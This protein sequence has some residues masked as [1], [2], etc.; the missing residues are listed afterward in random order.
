[1]ELLQVDERTNYPLT[2]SVDDLGDGFRLT[3]H[4]DESVEAARICGYMERAL[5]GI[6]TALES[7]PQTAVHMIDV[8]PEQERH[9]VL[10][11]WNA[12]AAENGTEKCIHELFEEQVVRRPGAVALV[13]EGKELTYGELNCRANQLAHY[14]RDM[15]VG[16]EVRVGI[17]MERSLE[18]VI[19]LLGVWKA[20]GVYVPVDPGYPAERVSYMLEDAQVPVLLT[21]KHLVDRLPVSWTQVVSVDSRWEEIAK[22]SEENPEIELDPQNT[23]YVIYT[24]GSTGQ[25]K[26]VV[27]EHRGLC[28][29][30][31]AQIGGFG[32]EVE[33]RILQFASFSFDASVWEFMMALCRGAVLHMPGPGA[34]LMEET[35]VG[36]VAEHGIT[37]VTLPPAVLAT[38]GEEKSL[39]SVRTLIV[40][41]DTLT[42]ELAEKWIQDRE[43]INAYGPTEATV[44]ATMHRWEKG[45]GKPPIGRPIANTRVYILDRY[46]EPA[47][48][49]VTGEI[50]IGGAC[51]ARGYLNRPGLTAE[52]FVADPF[53]PEPGARMYKTGDLG[54]WLADGNIDFLGR[55]DLQVKIRGFRIE[56]GE[57]EARLR[58]HAGVR[59]AVVVARQ[60]DEPGDKRLVAYYTAS[61]ASEDEPRQAVSVE[62]LRAHLLTKLPEYMVPS[63]WVQLEVLPLTPNDKLDRKALPAPAAQSSAGRGYEAPQGEVETQIAGI[64]AEILRLEQVGR[65]DNFFELG[66]HS[67][68][69]ARLVSRLREAFDVD[70]P[71][72]EIFARPVLSSLAEYVLDK[73]LELYDPDCLSEALRYMD[74]APAGNEEGRGK[75][76]SLRHAVDKSRL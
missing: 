50:F 37:H 21:Q 2:L 34:V 72:N 42:E 4:V 58:E 22:H 45:T 20:G 5:D 9:Q 62:E 3:V 31:T 36:M 48:V 12:T 70:V 33:S 59:E 14:L 66:G 8:L 69:A 29:M 46:G 35:L 7:A 43:L 49:G 39:D 68:L 1:V 60:D 10:Q 53:A 55:N 40:A 65:H 15:G 30:V 26:G 61:R 71:I 51:V 75:R 76:S 17:S 54:R 64:W 6:V 47:P 56:L 52:R 18:P 19:G 25:P 32:V 41:G 23:A 13:F 73:E 63:A 74:R 27:I 11:E 44:C 57:I 28:N 67:L 16:A 24:S 38:L